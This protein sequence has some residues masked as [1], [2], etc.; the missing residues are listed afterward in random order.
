[1][2]KKCKGA[3]KHC[4][5]WTGKVY[6]SMPPK[7][8]VICCWCGK[9]KLVDYDPRFVGHKHGKHYPGTFR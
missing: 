5:H 2:K 4:W 7:F 1:M 3:R 6:E 9:T 8:G